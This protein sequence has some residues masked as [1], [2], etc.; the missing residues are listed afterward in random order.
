MTEQIAKSKT[1][2]LIRTYKNHGKRIKDIEEKIEN[3]RQALVSI[4]TALDA[5]VKG[6]K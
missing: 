1:D 2:R 3:H 5:I 4:Q 6:A